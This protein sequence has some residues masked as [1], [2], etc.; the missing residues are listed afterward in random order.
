MGL[1]LPPDFDMDIFGVSSGLRALGKLE[2]VPDRALN[3]ICAKIEKRRLHT[4]AIAGPDRGLSV[5]FFSK[6]A[7][8]LEKAFKLEKL[9]RARGVAAQRRDASKRIGDLLGYPECCVKAFTGP[10]RQNDIEILLA[11][12][13]SLDRSVDPILNFFPRAV[14]P[15][16]FIPCSLGCKAATAHAENTCKTLEKQLGVNAE[17]VR[18]ALTGIVL[19]FQGPLFLWFRNITHLSPEGFHFEEVV[20]SQNLVPEINAPRHLTGLKQLDKLVGSMASGKRLSLN[21]EG[22]VVYAEEQEIFPWKQTGLSQRF[23]SFHGP[24]S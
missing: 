24:E 18:L 21:P 23:I 4:R 19:W 9:N 7:G 12:D 13:G 14:A 22:L 1:D 2:H 5:V 16:G 8:I 20:T 6:K 10:S 15:V 17:A 11:L 3:K